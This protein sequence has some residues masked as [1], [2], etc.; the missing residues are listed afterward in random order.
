[1][2]A[3]SGFTKG[4]QLLGEIECGPG[5]AGQSSVWL[6]KNKING[7]NINMFGND[8]ETGLPFLTLHPSPR[9]RNRRKAPDTLDKEERRRKV[10]ELL[11]SLEEG[12]RIRKGAE[13][14][15]LANLQVFEMAQNGFTWRVRALLQVMAWNMK[16]R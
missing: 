2:V 6:V 7:R 3:H 10:E 8:R 14:V 11:Q 15:R 12:R 13:L 4:V 5:G 9:H 1:M 16:R